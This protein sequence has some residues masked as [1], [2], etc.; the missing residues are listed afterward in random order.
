LFVLEFIS[1]LPF[2]RNNLFF[3]VSTEL[4]IGNIIMAYG[5]T[6]GKAT[7]GYGAAGVIIVVILAVAVYY[8]L[9]TG[10]GLSVGFLL[11]IAAN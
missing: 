1:L 3:H 7:Y 2:A 10:K 4:L 6:K 8:I 11:F 9:I 5:S